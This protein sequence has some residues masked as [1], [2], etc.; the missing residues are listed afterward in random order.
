M[1]YMRNRLIITLLLV[2]A[3]IS[4]AGWRGGRAANKPEKPEAKAEKFRKVRKPVKGQ[5]IVVL[6]NDTRSEDVE[7]VTNKLIA[8]HQGTTRSVYK[9][10]LKGFAI[11]MSEA[12]AVALSG[13]PEVEYVQENGVISASTTQSNPVWGLDR[14]DQRDLPR[15]LRYNFA[16]VSTGAGVHAYVVDSGIQIFHEEFRSSTGANRASHDANFV[17]WDWNGINDCN[18]HGTFVAGVIGGRQVGVA[19]DVRLH[20]V[21][22]LDC[23]GNGTTW[24]VIDGIDWV[25]NNH[26]KPAV[27]NLSLGSGIDYGVEDAIRNSMRLKGLTFVVAAGNDNEDAKDTSPAR[28]PEVITVG[29]MRQGDDKRSDFSNFGPAVDLFAPGESI[30]SASHDPLDDGVFNNLTAGDGT[31]F[32]APHV[33]GVVA[34]FLQTF[35]NVSPAVVEGAIRNAATPNKIVDPGPGSSNLLLYSGIHT[36]FAR[37][38]S[39]PPINESDNFVDSGVDVGPNEWLAMTGFGSINSGVVFSGENGPEGWNSIDNNPSL[40]LPGSRPFSLL[41]NLNAQNFYIGR[42]AATTQQFTTP[43]R[44]FLRTND[45]LP[46]NGSGAFNCQIQ[47]W[48]RLPD[49]AANMFVPAVSKTVVVPGETINVSLSVRNLGPGTWTTAQSYRLGEIGNPGW[50]G[51]RVPLPND[52]APNTTVVFNFTVTAPSTPG[53]YNFQWRM[54]QEGVQWFGDVSQNVPITVLSPSNQA[55]FVS[56]TVPGVMNVGEPYSVSVTM[57]NAG[58]TTWPAGSVFK[59]GSQNPQDNMTWGLNRVVLTQ[60]V[61]PGAQVTFFF[62]V[63]APVNPGKYNFQWRMVKEG[64]EWFGAFTPNV[65]VTVKLPPCARC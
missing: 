48:R 21:K 13:E 60:S 63:N 10:A 58:N 34:R 46:G 39:A 42:S 61:A 41:G 12:E 50:A 9:H 51:L 7:F 37:Q 22:V 33:T 30:T 6:K 19:K 59:L 25:T 28:M 17:W 36:S 64:V 5:Y 49:V 62:N 3:I 23:G 27:V 11:Q 52:V 43:A 8:K 16:N 55:E 32:A 40:P 44:L 26:V 53:N 35:T 38:A 18:G 56:Q 31:S 54:L 1:K 45:D 57:R 24:S 15:D 20:N 47:V 14:I 2:T 4:F 29:A 65:Q